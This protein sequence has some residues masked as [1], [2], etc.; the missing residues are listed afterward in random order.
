MLTG[1][2]KQILIEKLC[3]FLEEHQKKREKARDEV[4]KFLVK[5]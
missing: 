1:E 5:D 3:K 2:L 4:E